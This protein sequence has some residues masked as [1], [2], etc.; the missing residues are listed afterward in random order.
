MLDAV[1]NAE[2]M[3]DEENFGLVDPALGWNWDGIDEDADDAQELPES[4]WT[5]PWDKHED[6]AARAP[7]TDL[8]VVSVSP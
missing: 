6:S 7:Y 3:G 2:N 1:I 5:E 8:K 4:E